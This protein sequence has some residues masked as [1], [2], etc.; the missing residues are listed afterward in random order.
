MNGKLIA[1][2]AVHNYGYQAEELTEEYGSDLHI[3]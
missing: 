2:G 3:K 1:L